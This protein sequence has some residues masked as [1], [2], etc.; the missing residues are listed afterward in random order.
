[1]STCLR[2]E[3]GP[4]SQSNDIQSNAYKDTINLNLKSQND[5]LSIALKALK[6]KNITLPP[7]THATAAHGV[8][9]LRKGG[10]DLLEVRNTGFAKPLA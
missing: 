6:D 5:A 7:S 10:E 2:P 3:A 9:Y 4:K 1:L 8:N